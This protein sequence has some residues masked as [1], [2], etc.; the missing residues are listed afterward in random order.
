MNSTDRKVVKLPGTINGQQYILEDC[1]EFLLDHVSQ[2]SS[3]EIAS[4]VHLLWPHANFAPATVRTVIFFCI[5]PQNQLSKCR[6]SC[7]L[8]QASILFNTKYVH[9]RIIG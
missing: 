3:F 1:T 4:G 2:V 5:V 7:G 9:G 8:V 6:L